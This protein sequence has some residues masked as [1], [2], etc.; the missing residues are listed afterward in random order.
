MF[1]VRNTHHRFHRLQLRRRSGTQA[2]LF[3]W[4]DPR[5]DFETLGWCHST[6]TWFVC[7]FHCLSTRWSTTSPL[8][9]H[10]D[11][12]MPAG[13]ADLGVDLV[14]G[15]FASSVLSLAGAKR[16]NSSRTPEWALL[17]PF[18]NCPLA[19]LTCAAIERPLAH[20]SSLAETAESSR[21]IDRLWPTLFFI[22]HLWLAF[23]P[24]FQASPGQYLLRPASVGLT[25]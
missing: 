10:V 14:R 16:S 4:R 2:N 19:W 9:G 12:K 25:A 6:E 8:N 22:V 23:F 20:Y 11:E 3:R 1:S 15:H 24:C 5:E 18:A 13:V 7:F 17:W 21:Y